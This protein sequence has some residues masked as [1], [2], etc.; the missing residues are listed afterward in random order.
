MTHTVEAVDAELEVGGIKSPAQDSRIVALSLRVAA[1]LI[2]HLMVKDKL[3]LTDP[4]RAVEYVRVSDHRGAIRVS[5]QG[6]RP[7]RSAKAKLV[8]NTKHGLA[9]KLRQSP[10]L[11]EV[12]ARVLWIA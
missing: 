1:E 3:T 6:L 7:V 11:V 8:K 10:Q 2:E 4:A 12:L 9:K 5:T